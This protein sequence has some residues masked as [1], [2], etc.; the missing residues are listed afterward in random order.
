M[1]PGVR[2]FDDILGVRPD[3]DLLVAPVLGPE[4]GFDHRGQLHAVVRGRCLAAAVGRD[5]TSAALVLGNKGP[6]A[7][8]TGVLEA[9]AIGPQADHAFCPLAPRFRLKNSPGGSSRRRSSS[10]KSRWRGWWTTLIRPSIPLRTL[11]K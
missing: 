8:A 11:S 7:G 3:L 10:R 1:A 5:G 2:S 4:Q 9:A 6:A